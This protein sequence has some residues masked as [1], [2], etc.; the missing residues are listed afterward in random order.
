[1]MRNK[2]TP[3]AAQVIEHRHSVTV[4]HQAVDEIGTNEA[5]AS[6]H[7]DFHY[8]FALIRLGCQYRAS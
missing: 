6:C 1:M 7:H 2:I 8:E 4:F 3:A 5:G